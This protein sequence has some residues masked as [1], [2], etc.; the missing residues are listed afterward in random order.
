LVETDI[1]K[2]MGCVEKQKYI[3]CV[4]LLGAD[5]RGLKINHITPK[6]FI[7]KYIKQSLYNFFYVLPLQIVFSVYLFAS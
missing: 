5:F 4:F 6:H 2:I 3:E 1:L 7:S